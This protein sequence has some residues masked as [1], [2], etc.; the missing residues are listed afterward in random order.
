MRSGSMATLRD[1]ATRAGVDVS[2]ASKVLG[3]GNIRVA[4]TTRRRIEAAARALDYTPNAYAQGLRL[5]R[6]GA[7]AMAVRDTTNYVFPEIVEGAEEAAER[8]GTSL[9]LVKQPEG[10]HADRL[11]SVIR[12]GR[13]D[14]WI[15]AD[16]APCDGFFDDLLT[17]RVPFITLN[18][19]GSG[20]GPHVCLDDEAGFRVQAERIVEMG[21]RR[22]AFISIQPESFV[23]RHCRHTFLKRMASLY[24]PLPPTHVLGGSFEG[25]DAERLAEAVLA[26]RPRPTAVACGSMQA[27]ARLIESL[28]ARGIRVPEEIGVVGYHDPPTALTARP[29]LTTIRLPSRAQGRIAVERLI[30]IIDGK[31]KEFQGETVQEAP[32]FVLRGSLVVPPA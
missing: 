30:E 29:P 7:L 27:A 26:L 1:V 20:V 16:E 25:D 21:H 24:H 13:M 11:L 2:T 14:G 5:R 19:F 4:E 9:F 15:F 18:R 3:G 8:L 12:Q 22:V 23:S 32:E 28:V 17:L 31:R 6:K 10:S